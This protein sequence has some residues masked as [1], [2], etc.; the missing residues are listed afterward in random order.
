MFREAKWMKGKI[1]SSLKEYD[2]KCKILKK[3]RKPE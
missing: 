1:L 3:R 2:F